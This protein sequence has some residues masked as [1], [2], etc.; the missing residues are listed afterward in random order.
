MVESSDARSAALVRLVTGVLEGG[1]VGPYEGH[2]LDCKEDPSC[3]APDGL[4]QPGRQQSDALAKTVADASACFANADG[5][6]VVVGVDDKATG[7]SAFVGTPCDTSW[8]RNRIR[9]LIN[10][11]VLVSEVNVEDSRI[12]TVTVEPS[13]IPVADSSGKYRSRQGRDCH[14]MTG[15]ELGQFSVNRSGADWSS[16]P[17]SS[18]VADIDPTAMVQL[19]AWLHQSGEASRVELANRDDGALLDQLGLSTPEGQL[20]RAGEL[21]GVRLRG[22]GPLVD[23]T[24]RPAPGADAVVR[25]DPSEVPLAVVLAEVESAINDRN[26]VSLYSTGLTVGQ[27]RALPTLALREALVNAVAHRDW[28]A[29]GP[30]RVQLEGTMLTVTNPGGFLPGIT[31]ETVIT[32]PPRAR[33]PRLARALRGLRLAE[34]EGI[35]V[36][37]MYRETVRQGLSTP[38]IDEFPDG[39]GVRCVLV[40]GPPDE[41]V[42]AVVG[43]L[44]QPAGQ[45]VDIL[46]LLHRLLRVA[47]VN[48][49]QL[50]PVIQKSRAQAAAAIE[51]AVDAGLVAS[52]SQVGYYGLA[53]GPRHV[54]AK[55]LPYLR[56]TEADYARVIGD[57]L[58]ASGEIRA[59]DLIDV[60][61]IKPVRA[62]QVLA[63]AVGSGLLERH[64]ELGA[65]V[66]YTRKGD[67]GQIA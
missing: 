23:F 18:T 24:F 7:R 44:S 42:V 25:I 65:G 60:C 30:I 5:G 16:A 27:F 53:N 3:R 36:D 4:L 56:R 51:R 32:A 19:R 2:V 15:G 21:L 55:K 6:I 31:S 26:P 34:S 11:E 40:G 54:L 10:V 45:D 62:S 57:L 50:A 47:T 39:G 1:H 22:R 48:A 41:A 13:S 14:V 59:R 35:G 49:T 58:G 8:L 61:G 66:Y 37:R 20:N 43:A 9:Q 28:A 64:G 38:D 46:L 63:H 67:S 33:N 17:S 29:P 52:S 12:V